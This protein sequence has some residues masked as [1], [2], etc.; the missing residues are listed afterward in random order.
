MKTF[1]IGFKG[2]YREQS[3]WFTDHIRARTKP[4]ALKTFARKHGIKTT[5][6]ARPANW[7]WWD[8]EWLMEFHYVKPVTVV[9]CSVCQGTG[10]VSVSLNGRSA[11]PVS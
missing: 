6:S 9:K 4:A 8:N 3:D 7:Q 10:L 11:R 5:K 2:F 1:E